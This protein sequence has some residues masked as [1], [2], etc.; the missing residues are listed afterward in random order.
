MSGRWILRAWPCV[1][2]R[3]GARHFLF[4]LQDPEIG[5]SLND[6]VFDNSKCNN[7]HAYSRIESREIVNEDAE[8]L[9]TQFGSL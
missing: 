4:S 1:Q 8:I 9:Y 2:L 3:D 5:G 7:F 6:G